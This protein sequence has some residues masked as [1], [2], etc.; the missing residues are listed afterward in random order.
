MAHKPT[1]NPPG[2]AN[3]P[4]R[5]ERGTNE[6]DVFSGTAA[7]DR[8]QGRQGDDLING[9][10]GDDHLLGQGG[11]DTIHGGGGGDTMTGGGGADVFRFGSPT[12]P[13]VIPWA[14]ANDTFGDR[15]TDFEVGVDTIDLSAFGTR[16]AFDGTLSD[17]HT[18]RFIGT[19]GF[20]GD[21]V[22]TEVRYEHLPDGTTRVTADGFICSCIKEGP[23]AR[24]DLFIVLD[25]HL[26]LSAGDFIL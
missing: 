10:A 20:H 26:T 19:G 13:N 25:G 21:Q 5:W 18:F 17:P 15:I 14:V 2:Q 16:R 9:G 6:D 1:H 4:P 8:Y 23:D 3:R 22:N 7:D 11:N 24:P 12:A